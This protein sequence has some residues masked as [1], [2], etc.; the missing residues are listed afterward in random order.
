VAVGEQQV[1][2]AAG[3]VH[4]GQ[5]H[6][7]GHNALVGTQMTTGTG[8]RGQVWDTE[9]KCRDG[10]RRLAAFP[11]ISHAFPFTIQRRYESIVTFSRSLADNENRI[12]PDT[13][14]GSRRGRCETR[15]LLSWFSSRSS[16]AGCCLPFGQRI[17]ACRRHRS[18][19]IFQGS[20]VSPGDIKERPPANHGCG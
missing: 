11:G 7:D 4:F 17:H 15:Y 16:G 2:L 6:T 12:C 10:N 5:H 1:L 14:S 19:A 18:R 8:L 20:T 3:D 9:S 13:N